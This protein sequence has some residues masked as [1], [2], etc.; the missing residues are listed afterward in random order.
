MIFAEREIITRRYTL[1][2]QE[3]EEL[4]SALDIQ[5][6]INNYRH[7]FSKYG[8][9]DIDKIKWVIPHQPNIHILREISKK[10]NIPFTK[11]VVTLDKFGN[12]AGATIPM[13]LDVIKDQINDG[14]LIL[15]AAV[16][17]GMTGGTILIEWKS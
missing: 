9:E 12:T 1:Y 15:M 4:D 13:A 2:L 7:I 16:G 3:V 5:V 14:D 10:T 6:W 17:A 8:R 11:F